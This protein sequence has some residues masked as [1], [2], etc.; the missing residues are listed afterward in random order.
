MDADLGENDDVARLIFFF[1]ALKTACFER[2]F[3]FISDEMFQICRI[4]GLHGDVNKDRGLLGYCNVW[5]FGYISACRSNILTS[6]PAITQ[7]EPYI[8]A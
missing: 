3:L 1:V 6:S 5:S 2:Q 8:L 7:V 4:W